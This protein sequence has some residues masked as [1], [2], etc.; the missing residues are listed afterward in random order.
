[1]G[2]SYSHDKPCEMCGGM[3][4]NVHKNRRYCPAC[5]KKM[6]SKI[7][8][9]IRTRRKARKAAPKPLPT[10]DSIDDVVARAKAAGRS[11]G[12]QVWFE[13]WEKELMRRGK[14]IA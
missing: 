2:P 1:M 4:L 7:K 3:M 8:Q 13:L 14:K 6:D 9:E 12:W 11:Y 5:R 10:G